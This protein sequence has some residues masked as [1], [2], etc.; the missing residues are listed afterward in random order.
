MWLGASCSKISNKK[1]YS[2]RKIPSSFL[3]P[4]GEPGYPFW[5]NPSSLLIGISSSQA[6]IFFFQVIASSQPGEDFAQS[7]PELVYEA[8]G[9]KAKTLHVQGAAEPGCCL[10]GVCSRQVG[11]N[12]F[13]ASL[14]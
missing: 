8:S 5:E 3:P 10:L 2:S 14:P 9:V 4:A 12:C 1:I 11:L 7:N 13:H 6:R